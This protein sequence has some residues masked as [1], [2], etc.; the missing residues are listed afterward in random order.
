MV[1]NKNS[2]YGLLS[3]VPNRRFL[4]AL[5]DPSDL[6]CTRAGLAPYLQRVLDNAHVPL[7]VVPRE[8]QINDTVI[9]PI[10]TAWPMFEPWTVVSFTTTPGWIDVRC[11]NTL[12]GDDNVTTVYRSEDVWVVEP[13]EVQYD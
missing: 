5:V 13:K 7:T 3:I 6:P 1:D 8:P 4:Q 9:L 10:E 2:F 12:Y 11:N